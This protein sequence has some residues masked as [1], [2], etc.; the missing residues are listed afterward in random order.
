MITCICIS[1]GRPQL[2]PIAY[3]SWLDQG[4]YR[5]LRAM[6]VLIVPDTEHDAYWEAT[7]GRGAVGLA[8]EEGQSV[9]NEI[10][11]MVR[12]SINNYF[13]TWDDDD[14]SP[15]DRIARTAAA[16]KETGKEPVVV[17]YNKGFF[18]NLR[19]LNGHLVECD[20]WPLWGGCLAWNRAA[21]DLAGGFHNRTCPGYDRSFVED[22]QARGGKVVTLEGGEGTLPVAFS[23]GKN[24]ATFLR[25]QGRPM[26][27]DLRKWMSAESF[28]AVK[29]A[30][31]WLIERRIFPQWAV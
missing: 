23:H 12:M 24:V 16:L 17:S 22:V 31:A 10:D 7:G 5:K 6:L 27:G 21:W 2:F 30:Q 29:R 15:P 14:W 26:E 3:Q 20:P 28:A 8:R 18:V 13:M 1:E 25:H 11:Y 9:P 19:S 4:D